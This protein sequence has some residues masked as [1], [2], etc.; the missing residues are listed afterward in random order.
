MFNDVLLNIN[1][2]KCVS[3]KHNMWIVFIF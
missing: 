2:L 1:V 3:F